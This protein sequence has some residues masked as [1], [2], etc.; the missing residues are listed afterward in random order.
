MNQNSWQ[1]TKKITVLAVFA[2]K[3]AIMITIIDKKNAE[4][5]L[6]REFS[7]TQRTLV[8]TEQIT[9]STLNFS[10]S[11]KIFCIIIVYSALH[12]S[13]QFYFVDFHEVL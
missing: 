4:N 8:N 3:I 9:E 11:L 7:Y 2:T 6:L 10:Q 1:S 13:R 12:K 5:Y